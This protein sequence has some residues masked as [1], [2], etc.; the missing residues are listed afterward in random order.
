MNLYVFDAR[1]PSF[2][3]T[4]MLQGRRWVDVSWITNGRSGSGTGP[5]GGGGCFADHSG[6]TAESGLVLAH[7]SEISLVCPRVEAK[8]DYGPLIQSLVGTNLFLLIV[9]HGGWDSELPEPR[10]MAW[11]AAIPVKDW[12]R[13]W[14]GFDEFWDAFVVS[15][16]TACRHPLV[17]PIVPTPEMP[18]T[19]AAQLVMLAWHSCLKELSELAQQK[20]RITS[21]QPE[22]VEVFNDLAR[23][24]AGLRSLVESDRVR[25]ADGREGQVFLSKHRLAIEK[26]IDLVEGRSRA[27]QA[28]VDARSDPAASHGTR[29]IST[30]VAEV[31]RL[32]DSLRAIQED[33]ES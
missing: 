9:H 19:Q 28:M 11:P 14:S 7:G 10:I 32:R 8:I 15:P 5:N 18:C 20:S 16:L 6:R 21:G 12:R 1:T 13:G 31:D 33:L 26:A 29:G 3:W 17:Q 22:I 25:R 2:P 23:I 4:E 30:I 27:L 24:V